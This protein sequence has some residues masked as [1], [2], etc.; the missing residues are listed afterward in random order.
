MKYKTGD[1]TVLLN[2][3]FIDN[4]YYYKGSI[5]KHEV[6][7]ADKDLF[8]PSQDKHNNAGMNQCLYYSQAD[9]SQN[10]WPSSKKLYHLEKDRAVYSRKIR[11]SI[12]DSRKKIEE[13]KRKEIEKLQKQIELMK[14]GEEPTSEERALDKSI[15]LIEE[16]TGLKGLGDI[17]A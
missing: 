8:S 12:R 15:R 13:K 9:G 5:V 16:R 2:L 10:S 3:Q 6:K 4:I 1:S 7:Y 11:E 17:K 14:N